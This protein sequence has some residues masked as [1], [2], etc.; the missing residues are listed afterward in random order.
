MMFQG[1]SRKVAGACRHVAVKRFDLASYQA[2]CAA[3]RHD[4]TLIGKLR[5][6]SH[7]AM[8]GENAHFA[9]LAES[10]GGI[11]RGA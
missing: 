3:L 7:G 5:F 4:Q 11:A 10:Q 8:R 6:H 9:I 1:C 2:G